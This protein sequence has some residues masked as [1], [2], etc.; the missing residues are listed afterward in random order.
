AAD[1]DAGTTLTY[2]IQGGA[3][4]AKFSINSSTGALSF[5]TAP[6]FEAPADVGANNVYDV[7]VRAS[8]STLFDDQAIAVTVTNVNEAPVITSNCGGDTA[9]VSVTLTLHAALPIVAADP[10]AGTTLT[11]SIQ[12]GADAAKF[13]INS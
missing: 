1:P 12:G 2:S 3:D 9:S 5:V 13:S 8:D 6:N 7:I 11:Y 10:D 4:A